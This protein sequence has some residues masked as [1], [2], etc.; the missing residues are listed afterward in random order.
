MNKTI[1][2]PEWVHLELKVFT[3]SNPKDN[4]IDFAGFAIM[5]EL[6]SRGHKFLNPAKNK[7]VF[8]NNKK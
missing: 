8:S 6:K 5:K 3:A 1:K 4:M 7:E 2:I